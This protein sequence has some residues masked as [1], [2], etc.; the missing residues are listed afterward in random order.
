MNK[1]SNIDLKRFSRQIILKD[2]GVH[3]Q[4]KF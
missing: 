4:K 2:V 3:G 1:I